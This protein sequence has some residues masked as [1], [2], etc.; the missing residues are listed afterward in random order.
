MRRKIALAVLLAALIVPGGADAFIDA[1][2]PNGQVTSAVEGVVHDVNNNAVGGI[3]VG[4][5]ATHFSTPTGG[6][7]TTD[8]GTGAYKVCAD[9][10]T[11]IVQAQDLRVPPYFAEVA[12]PVTTFTNTQTIDFT[13][14]SGYPLPYMANIS[15][16]P[17]AIRTNCCTDAQRTFTFT[18][19]TKM[20]FGAP[21]HVKIE[22]TSGQ[23][24]EMT[25]AGTENGGPDNGGWNLWTFSKVFGAT[26]SEG[27][28]EARAQAYADATNALKMT[29]FT[30][31]SYYLDNGVPQFG[32]TCGNEVNDGFKPPNNP[33]T[34][35]P[36]PLTKLGVCDRTVNPNVAVSGLDPY[37]V[38]GKIC[39]TTTECTPVSTSP[40]GNQCLINSSNCQTFTPV[41]IG[42]KSMQW[43]PAQPLPLTSSLPLGQGYYLWYEIKDRAGNLGH[44]PNGY[45]LKITA[46]GGAPV[47]IS[48]NTPSDFG[49]GN[50]A[51]IVIGCS[52]TT[53]SSIPWVSFQITDD[54]GAPDVDLGTLRVRIYYQSEQSQILAGTP[55]SGLI[56]DYDPT[57]SA[58][59]KNAGSLANVDATRWQ[60]TATGFRLSRQLPG[61][62]IVATSVGDRG[63][64]HDSYGWHYILVGVAA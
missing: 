49:S 32:A 48:A 52:C 20:A 19:R 38:M 5:Y 30:R 41:L 24:G 12:Q 63:G 60:F 53:P 47:L 39:P 46:Q 9:H 36:R 64:N 45:E 21:R 29:E 11:Y 43:S 51:G 40:T 8:F 37:T 50:S 34:T 27:A 28:F 10:N 54:D 31:V 58:T 3:R 23:V 4:L 55:L 22:L 25:P 6:T 44:T 62:Y 16:S 61:R 33:G 26:S 1:A 13:P 56:Y 42:G 18:Y 17:A 15:V 35:N 57:A 14:A 7:D 59:N 2:C